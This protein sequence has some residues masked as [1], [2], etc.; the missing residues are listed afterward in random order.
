MPAIPVN[1]FAALFDDSHHFIYFTQRKIKIIYMG[2]QNLTGRADNWLRRMDTP[3][4]RQNLF[5][6]LFVNFV[7]KRITGNGL[8]S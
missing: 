8:W 3:Y 2:Q 5:L 1:S 7:A 6:L 4:R